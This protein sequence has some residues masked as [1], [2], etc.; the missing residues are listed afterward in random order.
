MAKEITLTLEGQIYHVLRCTYGFNREVD[1][2][3]RPTTG[4]LG[5]DI[6]LEVESTGDD[7]LLEKLLGR[8]PRPVSG[9]VEIFDTKERSPV[10]ILEWYEGYIYTVQEGMSSFFAMPMT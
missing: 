7:Y 5:G 10:R 4:L 9:K 8:K 2:R 3:G 1:Y 6:Q